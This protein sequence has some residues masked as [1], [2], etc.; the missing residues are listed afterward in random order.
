MPVCCNYWAAALQSPRWNKR[1]QVTKWRNKDPVQPNKWKRKTRVLNLN[2]F[3]SLGQTTRPR[4]SWW[5][6]LGFLIAHLSSSHHSIYFIDF[7]LQGC[8]QNQPWE[9]WPMNLLGR[10]RGHEEQ[11]W[12]WENRLSD[13]LWFKGDVIQGRLAV[14]RPCKHPSYF[15]PNQKQVQQNKHAE[16]HFEGLTLKEVQIGQNLLLKVTVRLLKIT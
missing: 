6:T 2:I 10:S 7:S 11:T 4:S 12:R 5:Q 14:S 8:D 13:T 1:P 15:L 9:V 16:N 3:K